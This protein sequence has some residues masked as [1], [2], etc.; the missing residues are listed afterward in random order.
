MLVLRHVGGLENDVAAL[1]ERPH[2]VESERLKMSPQVGHRQLVVT[3]D[4]HAAK[5]NYI[6]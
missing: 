5:Q 6:R 1:D 3:A 4:V 2:V